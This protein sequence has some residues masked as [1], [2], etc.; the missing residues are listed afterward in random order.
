MLP[1]TSVL[2]SILGW[3]LAGLFLLRF[4]KDAKQLSAILDGLRISGG[5]RH[6]NLSI[7]LDIVQGHAVPLRIQQTIFLLCLQQARL[8]CLAIPEGGLRIVLRHPVPISV[9][10]REVKRD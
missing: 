7:G 9:E 1:S 4:G 2:R 10:L 3:K 5:R 6:F 8:S